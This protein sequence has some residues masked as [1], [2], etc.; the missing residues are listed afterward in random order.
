MPSKGK[1]K[2]IP[3]TDEEEPAVKDAITK[4]TVTKDTVTMDTVTKDTGSNKWM[5]LWR[6]ANLVMCVF[7]VLA[8][9]VQV[10]IYRLQD[11]IVVKSQKF[12]SFE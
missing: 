6:A 8:A 3:Q 9:Y 5:A 7:F 2:Q 10:C 12:V 1:Y 11:Y 4:E